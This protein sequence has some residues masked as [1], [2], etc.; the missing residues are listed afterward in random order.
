MSDADPAPTAGSQSAGGAS[1][2]PGRLMGTGRRILW[3]Y[4]RK[5]RWATPS[6][7][8]LG[9]GSSISESV[10]IGLIVVFLY[11]V[12]G[13][14][15]A[16]TD[17]L[18]P[19]GK[20]SDLVSGLGGGAFAIAGLILLFV[21]VRAALSYGYSLVVARVRGELGQRVRDDLHTVYLRMAYGDFRKKDQ[22]DLLN[23]LATTSWSLSDAYLAVTRI[24]AN[25]CAIGIFS[26]LIAFSSGVLFAIAASGSLVL[27][28]A[29]R[30]LWRPARRM[31]E[32]MHQANQRL[33]EQMLTTLHGMRA[34]RIFGQESAFEEKYRLASED[35]RRRAFA[36][37][38]QSALIHPVTEISY[39]LLLCAL[40]AAAQAF[41]VPLAIAIAVIAMLYR[42]QPHV[43]ELEG[44][45]VGLSQLEPMLSR[46]AEMLVES[47]ASQTE[48]GSVEFSLLRQSIDFDKVTF[49]YRSENKSALADISFSIPARRTT[50]IVGASGAGKS[51]IVSLL[52]RLYAP[53]KGRILIDGV[54]LSDLRA[55]SWLAR[56]AM[57]GQDV[58]LIEGTIE[59]NILLSN[60][61]AAP[62]VVRAAISDAC[63]AEIISS[64]PDGAQTWIGHEGADLSGGQRQRIGLARALVRMPEVLILDE[65][66][67]AV[68][69][70][71]AD[72]IRS[73]LRRRL[74]DKT[75][76][77]IAHNETELRFAD[78]VVDL[79]ALSGT[80]EYEKTSPI[81]SYSN[82]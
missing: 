2:G 23:L 5:Y 19:L 67:S 76:I 75:L 34:A 18:G 50:V 65:A 10:G 78:H 31:G 20:L 55:H 61:H 28:F 4:A 57:A 66:L 60:P 44:N 48:D 33:A 80:A 14:T 13:D 7:V 49:S 41:A 58:D 77:V 70:S 21:G 25:L 39:I 38:A 27:F 53:Q 54:P 79:A 35:A 16:I 12:I 42:L 52:L 24:G 40:L 74:K 15:E 22:G 64:L 9:I 11:A 17:Q 37:E 46:V 26:V 63:A 68:D 62:E 81:P 30:L 3:E 82:R 56:T 51:T 73:N 8:L 43:R 29:M 36:L 69:P 45:L 32:D 1:Q 59:E 71:T 72:I 47:R 6:L